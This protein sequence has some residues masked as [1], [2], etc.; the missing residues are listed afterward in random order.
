M[1]E[2]ARTITVTRRDEVVSSVKLGPFTLRGVTDKTESSITLDAETIRALEGAGFCVSADE[3]GGAITLSYT[4]DDDYEG[5]GLTIESY[6]EG[7]WAQAEALAGLDFQRYLRDSGIL[8]GE[9][10]VKLGIP[11]GY[12]KNGKWVS[13]RE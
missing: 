5:K 12:L 3:P 6:D 10:W 8:D 7:R 1:A 9:S 13:T 11:S 4:M 2:T